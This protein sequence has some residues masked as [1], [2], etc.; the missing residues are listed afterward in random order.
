MA[1]TPEQIKQAREKYGL[2]TPSAQP[3]ISGSSRIDRLRSV[4]G[5]STPQAQAPQEKSLLNK[6]GDVAGKGLKVGSELL[7]NPLARA[8]LT[9][10]VSLVRGLQGK[11][12]PVQTPFG[13]VKPFSQ[14]K[15][16]E[17]LGK[18]FDVGVAGLPVERLVKTPFTK[19]AQKLYK[20]ALKPSDVKVAG[21]VVQ[22]GEELAK[23]GLDER[24]WLTQSGVEKTASKIEHFELMLGDAIESAKQAGQKISTKGITTYLDEAKK[25]FSNQ[26]N[27]AE[28]SKAI[29]AIDDIGKNFVKKYGDEIPIEKAQDIK[30]ATGQAL[31]KYYDKMT[32][33]S[34]EGEKQATRFL[35][36][37]IVEKA[38]IVGNINKRLADL[39]KFD[40]ALSKS[41]NRISNLN[42]LGIG[43]KL[44]LT[45]GGSKSALIGLLSDLADAPA[46]KSG[47]AINL[48]RFANLTG[49]AAKAVKIPLANLLNIIVDEISKDK[50]KQ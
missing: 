32:S 47:I 17:S 18:A 14:L 9:P 39:Y 8:G 46:I 10:A 49:G 3:A 28:G 2:D 30:V 38:P 22:K 7:I 13:E 24:V 19:I 33:A 37:K 36:E 45:S 26:I 44:G 4:A 15:P 50:T 12:E 40:Q 5:I 23:I 16:M 48:S 21:K 11:E 35:K 42:L 31:R 41:A 34:I 43:T 27:I 6:V 1:L 29:K 20:S 25:F